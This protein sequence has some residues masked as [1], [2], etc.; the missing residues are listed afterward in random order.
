V[1][2]DGVS[3]VSVLTGGV[4]CTSGVMAGDG[5]ALAVWFIDDFCGSLEQL[6]RVAT[7]MMVTIRVFMLVLL[8]N[9]R[10]SESL[11]SLLYGQ[12]GVSFIQGFTACSACR[13]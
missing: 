9:L 4:V 8:S 3:L 1:G 2:D 7:R 11:H 12:K 6:A 10:S 13:L 5:L